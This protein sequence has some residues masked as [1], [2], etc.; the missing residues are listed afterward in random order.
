LFRGNVLLLPESYESSAEASENPGDGAEDEAVRNN[1][2]RNT[3]ILVLA[4][5]LSGRRKREE[6]V[7]ILKRI[8]AAR[9]FYFT[10]P[11]PEDAPLGRYELVSELYLD[12]V[13]H[14]SLTA[15]ED[16]F[17]VERVTVENEG[18]GR[19]AVRNLSPE[20]V[21][22]KIMEYADSGVSARLENVPAVQ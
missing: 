21:P 18:D 8:R 2:A 16:F 20:P 14:P 9:H 13:R 5:Y 11:V 1:L 15:E 6:L 22:V 10:Y 7:Q 4:D 3:P 17:L 19:F 12:G